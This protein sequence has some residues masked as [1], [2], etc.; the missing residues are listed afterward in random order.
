MRTRI[1]IASAFLL[2]ACTKQPDPAAAAAPGNA[3]ADAPAATAAETPPSS[4][5]VQ[6]ALAAQDRFASDAEQ[7]A[8]RKP[9]AILEM[10]EVQP[11]MKVIDYLAGGGY[12][13]ELLS[14]L[15]G[16][17]GEVV[18][19]NNDPYLNYAKDEPA[20]RYGENRL[21][22]V[23]QVASKPEE[24][25][26]DPGQYDAALMVQSYHDLH[27][28][29]KEG[30]WPATDPAA[31]LRKVAEALRPGGVV[32]VVDHVASAG[33]DPATSVDKLHRID[34]EIIKRDF[35][36]AGFSF[37]GESSA[38][39]NPADKYDAEVFDAAVRHRTDQVIY[40]FKKN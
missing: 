38:L 34:P 39:R 31:S 6:A 10:L 32:V 2:A 35:E 29:S 9:T 26:L 3:S 20:R 17:E 1:A 12:Y 5:A 33:S 18:A 16:P 37:A 22:N 7:D 21:P 36:A 28:V 15:V 23:R 8:W 13:T 40:K 11:G 30:H 25:P 19:Y 27:W 4:Q 24:L 14:R